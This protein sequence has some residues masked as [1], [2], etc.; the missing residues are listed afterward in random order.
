MFLVNA[1]LNIINNIKHSEIPLKLFSA[2]TREH[3]Y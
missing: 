2:M 1:V 3:G